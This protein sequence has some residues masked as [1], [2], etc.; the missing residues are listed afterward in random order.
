M[1][2]IGHS[3]TVDAN[4]SSTPLPPL[5]SPC[6]IHCPPEKTCNTLPVYPLNPKTLPNANLLMR[7]K[8]DFGFWIED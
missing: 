8:P 5:P 3:I 1:P 2:Q 4:G 6:V 7:G